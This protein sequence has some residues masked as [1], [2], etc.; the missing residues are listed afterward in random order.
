MRPE[1]EFGRVFWRRWLDAAHREVNDSLPYGASRFA[2]L[3]DVLMLLRGE[4]DVREVHRYFSAF[5]ALDWSKPAPRSVRPA[6]RRPAPT[7]YAVLRLWLDAGIHPPEGSSPGRDGALAQSLMRADSSAILSACRSAVARLR[8][9]GLPERPHRS[10]ERRAGQTVARV[11][12]VCTMEEARRM[13]LAVL[14][15]ISPFDTEQ[16]ARRLWVPASEDEQETEGS[17]AGA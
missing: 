3:E 8:V 11:A 5:L 7:T 1:D 10:E 15:P 12:P 2:H 14:V 9:V 6:A 4:L 13:P 16:L 17:H